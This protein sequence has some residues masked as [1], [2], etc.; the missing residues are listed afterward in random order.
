MVYKFT[1]NKGA[2]GKRS[3]SIKISQNPENNQS[4]K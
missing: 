1:E 2:Y 3:F 4:Y